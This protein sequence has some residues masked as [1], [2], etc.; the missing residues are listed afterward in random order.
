[1]ERLRDHA[2]NLLAYD[3]IVVLAGD[4]NVAPEDMDVYDAPRMRDSLC[5]HPEEQ[6]R[7][8]AMLNAGYT[9]AFRAAHPDTP[10]FTWWDYRAGAW[11]KNH[12]MR[13]DHLLLSPQAADKATRVWVDE[14]PR[15][16]EKA[17]DHTP[18]CVTLTL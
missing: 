18:V 2:E 14:A 3:E 16:K 6:K 8:R 9:D 11:S 4:Y 1:M 15:A 10:Q 7:Y 12:G 17:S 5:F 13:I